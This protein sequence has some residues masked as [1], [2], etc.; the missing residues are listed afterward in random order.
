MI[1]QM[2]ADLSVLFLGC[3]V[4][5]IL[6]Q[7]KSFKK[8]LINFPAMKICRFLRFLRSGLLTSTAQNPDSFSC[9]HYYASLWLSFLWHLKGWYI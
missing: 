5:Q 3:G 4:L 6:L 1:K 9:Y 2:Q 7:W 8:F